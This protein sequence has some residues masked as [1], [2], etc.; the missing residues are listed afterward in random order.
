MISIPLV[1]DENPWEP[2]ET[3]FVAETPEIK[4][5]FWKS[6]SLKT[7]RWYQKNVAQNSIRRCPFFPS[8]SHFTQKMIEKRGVFIG[9]SLFIDRHFYRENS[10]IYQLY[11]LIEIDGI[12][13]LDD[14]Y[15][16]ID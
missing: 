5:G 12:L 13:K 3:L 10:Q 4:T 2:E 9:A 6:L 11:G 7:T 15:P 16:D 8:C 1:Q 14:R